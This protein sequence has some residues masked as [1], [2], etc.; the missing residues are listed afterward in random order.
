M[1]KHHPLLPPVRKTLVIVM[2]ISAMMAG[3]VPGAAAES[4]QFNVNGA[5]G[6][7]VPCRIHLTDG[8]G[9][10]LKAF[11]QPFWH[12]H[13]VC[14][15]RVAVEAPARSYSYEIERGPECFQV[16]GLMNRTSPRS[17]HPFRR[18]TRNQP[19]LFFGWKRTGERGPYSARSYSAQVLPKSGEI[20]MPVA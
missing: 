10:P 19:S 7:T 6:E 9:K 8:K 16:F 18:S 15:G 3:L 13:L 2:T 20:A 17:I 1:F 12:D 11:G 4:I 5:A 14:S